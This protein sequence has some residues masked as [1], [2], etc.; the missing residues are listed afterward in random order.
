MKLPKDFKNLVNE[1]E[2]LPGIGQKSALRLALYLVDTQDANPYALA[3]ALV[4]AKDNLQYC[5]YCGAL[6]DN[7]VCEICSSSDRDKTKICV[8]E[9]I[10]DMLAIERANFFD[11]L[12]HVLG[13]VISPL[14]DVTEDKIRIRQLIMRL[15]N[16]REVIFALP[17]SL[18][19][20]TTFLIIKEKIHQYS[21]N[22]KLTRVAIGLPVGANIDY[23]D[24]LTLMQSFENRYHF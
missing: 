8:V 21:T 19:A 9:N 17:A 2:K 1:I 13:G 20:D 10:I 15:D 22:I 23:A 11:G 5:K 3:S 24:P 6:S 18:E 14:D 7:E 16:V 4:R 12:Y